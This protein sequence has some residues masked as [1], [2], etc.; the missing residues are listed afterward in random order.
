MGDARE[1]A[2]ERRVRRY[3]WLAPWLLL[4]C[5]SLFVVESAFD[6]CTGPST[7]GQALLDWPTNVLVALLM[8]CAAAAVPFMPFR[9]GGPVR[10]GAFVVLCGSIVW[11][12]WQLVFVAVYMV[13]TG[14]FG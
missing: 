13:A 6:A 14:W 3:E 12:G 10:V 7:F 4:G 5:L 1:A 11:V 9:R 8:G 2:A